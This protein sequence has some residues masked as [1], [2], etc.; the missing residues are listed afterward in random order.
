MLR[1]IVLLLI[2]ANTAVWAWHQ[3]WIPPLAGVT[4]STSEGQERHRAQIHPERL[5]VLP[6]PLP[7]ATGDVEG[8]GPGGEAGPA[9]VA[10]TNP[11]GTACLQA[12]PFTLGEQQA[13][14]AALARVLPPGSWVA[15]ET[16]VSGPWLVYMGPFGDAQALER[17]MEELRRIRDLNFEEV[18]SPPTLALGVS[19]GRYTEQSQAE[20]ALE[21]LRARGIR[22]ARVVATRPAGAQSVIRVPQADEAVRQRLEEIDL[23]P[24]RTFSSC[25]A[26]AG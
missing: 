22:T 4:P 26:E 6:P 13:V 23:P 24:G 9:P 8:S 19:L 1:A 15:Q 25:A 20:T 12:G 21:A 17:K 10:A 18:R 11:D 14:S 2:I 3:G 7:G 5:V 16:M